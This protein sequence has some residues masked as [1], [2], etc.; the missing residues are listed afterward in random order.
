MNNDDYVFVSGLSTSIKNLTDSF[1]VGVNTS[2]VSLGKSTNV[3]TAGNPAIEDIFVNQIPNNIS[4]GN[5]IRI[6]SGNTPNDEIASVLNVYKQQ[7]IIR[8]FRNVGIAHT[9]GSNVD[10]LNNQV[11]IPVKTIKFDSQQNDIV[12]FNAPQSIGLGTDGEAISTNYVTGETVKSVSIPNRQIYLPKHPFVTGQ[13]VKLNVPAVPNRQIDVANTDDP[14]DTVN[15]FSIPFNSNDTSIDLF[16]IKKSENYIGL[17]TI[18]IGS[19]SEG[20]YFKSNA[21]TVTGINTH[22]YNLSSQFDQVTGDIDKIV[23]TVTVNVAAADT[24][25]HNLQNDDIVS[26]NVVPNHTV[27]IGTTTP[28]EVN[29]NAEYQKLLINPINFTNTNVETNRINIE[30]H[31]FNTGD[32]VFY[33][34]NA[35]LGTGSYFVYKVN[36]RFFQLAETFNDLSANPIKLIELTNNSGGSKQI[37]APIKSTN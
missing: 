35:G 30:N 36:S 13:K 5:S 7:K 34:G 23:S 22:L 6:G 28:I 14:S 27:G 10:L 17:S 15:N 20:L 37:I 2:R 3:V 21:S 29:Y 24:T 12:Y 18:S 33:D 31:G 9:F 26:I 25:T 11:S 32:K 16:V 4:I 19:T 1:S 8:V